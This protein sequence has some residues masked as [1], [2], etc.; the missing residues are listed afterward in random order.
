MVRRVH[1][2]KSKKELYLLLLR[3]AFFR[4][5]EVVLHEHFEFFVFYFV[6]NGEFVENPAK[7]FVGLDGDIAVLA[8]NFEFQKPAI[9]AVRKFE[10]FEQARMFFANCKLVCK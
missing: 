1:R 7:L 3:C 4:G 8:E 10:V 5:G 2:P 9:P 6:H